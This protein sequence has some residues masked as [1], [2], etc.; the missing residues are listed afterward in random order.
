MIEGELVMTSETTT[1]RDR[2][3][4]PSHAEMGELFRLIS[5]Y[6]VS[7]ALYVVATHSIPDLLNL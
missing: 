1:P 5:G 3:A 2:L 4:A 6:R 7:Q